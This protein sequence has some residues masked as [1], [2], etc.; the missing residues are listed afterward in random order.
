MCDI[1]GERSVKRLE[2]LRE[3]GRVKNIWR[4]IEGGYKIIEKKKDGVKKGVN[5]ERGLWLRRW[6]LKS[7]NIYDINR[8]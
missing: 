1:E 6:V 4:M 8:M 5:D 3:V 2:I 7:E